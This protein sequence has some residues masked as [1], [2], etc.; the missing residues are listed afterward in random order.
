MTQKVPLVPYQLNDA[1]TIQR[2]DKQ[3]VHRRRGWNEQCQS[4]LEQRPPCCLVIPSYSSSPTFPPTCLPAYLPTLMVIPSYSSF[5]PTYLPACL[6]TYLP[7]PCCPVISS[8]PPTH[9]PTCL[10]TQKFVFSL[11]T[12]FAF[13]F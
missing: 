10:C 12:I 4:A 2:N 3:I 1:H 5:S 6:L 8:F 9:L 7:S 11:T 13:Q